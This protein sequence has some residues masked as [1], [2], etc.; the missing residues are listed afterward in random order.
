M[1]NKR[2]MI[3]IFLPLI[4]I[5][6]NSLAQFSINSFAIGVGSMRGVENYKQ[7][8]H[9][10]IAIGGQAVST[11]LQWAIFWGY[12]DDDINEVNVRD[13][14]VYSTYG[15]II[16]GRIE[17]EP[18]KVLRDW[19]IP[20]VVTT[21]FSHHF[22]LKKYIGGGDYDGDTKYRGPDALNSVELGLRI[23]S[24]IFHFLQI[25]AEA[26]H[27]FLFGKELDRSLYIGGL[28]VIF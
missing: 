19:I 4:V 14:A 27:L 21:G 9:P 10:E 6:A 12:W 8:F 1:K 18:A 20:I 13:K 15:H 16:G 17:F 22:I 25:R 23:Y 2:T 28:A 26:R 11:Y 5:T 7:V 3:L 24:N